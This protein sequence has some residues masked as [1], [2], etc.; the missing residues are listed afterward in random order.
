MGGE[1]NMAAFIGAVGND[2]NATTLI[3]QC[4]SDGIHPLFITRH[5][6]ATGMAA[7]LID[8]GKDRT[9]ISHLGAS[10]NFTPNDLD[11][12]K[13]VLGWGSDEDLGDGISGRRQGEGDGQGMVSLCL[14]S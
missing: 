3:S 4:K 12:F 1:S 5:G 2:D 7:M 13:N 10:K 9:S 11:Q 8:S 14:A 6:E